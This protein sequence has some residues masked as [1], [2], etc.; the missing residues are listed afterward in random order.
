M[1]L[2]QR[3]RRLQILMLFIQ[4]LFSAACQLSKKWMLSEK[5]KA[6][7]HE[8]GISDYCTAQIATSEKSE[9]RK[10]GPSTMVSLIKLVQRFEETGSLED[11]IRSV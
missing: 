4:I 11:R 7:F 5:C 10:R 1:A 9:D 2:V 8:Q 6:V 3:D